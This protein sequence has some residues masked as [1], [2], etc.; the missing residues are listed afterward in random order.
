MLICFYLCHGIKPHGLKELISLLKH[1]CCSPALL[2]HSISYIC[3][4]FFRVGPVQ[5]I[6]IV[7]SS[8]IGTYTKYVNFST[9]ICQLDFPRTG[10]TYCPKDVQEWV[11]QD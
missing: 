5:L 2:N 7:V 9:S 1:L 6:M 10:P 4:R 11:H 8:I 3:V